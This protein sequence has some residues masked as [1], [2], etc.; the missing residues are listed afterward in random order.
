[1][2]IFG[3]SRTKQKN[4]VSMKN[5]RNTNHFVSKMHTEERMRSRLLFKPRKSKVSVCYFSVV[6]ATKIQKRKQNKKLRPD[7]HNFCST[8][9]RQHKQ[10]ILCP[11]PHVFTHLVLHSSHHF[12]IN[13]AY[14]VSQ[15]LLLPWFSTVLESFQ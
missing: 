7:L 1:M 2:M 6:A 10:N 14:A 5:G 3:P 13:Y 15:K 12:R 8:A 4:L 9:C 11:V